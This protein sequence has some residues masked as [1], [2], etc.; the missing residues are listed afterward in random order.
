MTWCHMWLVNTVKLSPLLWLFHQTLTPIQSLNPAKRKK[1]KIKKRFFL[2]IVC[3]PLFRPPACLLK[4]PTSW[5][6]SLYAC[7]NLFLCLLVN[8]ASILTMQTS[9]VPCP[10]MASCS[11]STSL[12]Q[13]GGWSLLEPRPA[14]MSEEHLCVNT[15]K[16][17]WWC[18]KLN[19]CS[20]ICCKT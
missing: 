19:G 15:P 13:L 16:R 2:F 14:C 5:N 7:S 3:L 12:S 20:D 18:V 1:E 9:S 6:R 11:W 10:R 8:L 17:N 4:V